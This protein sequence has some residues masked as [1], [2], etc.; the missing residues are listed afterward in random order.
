[1]IIAELDHPEREW[2]HRL[3]RHRTIVNSFAEY[4]LEGLAGHVMED[5]GYILQV[6]WYE[7]ICCFYSNLSIQIHLYDFTAITRLPW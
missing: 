6:L 5:I 2:I 4:H 1:M 3:R 7:D